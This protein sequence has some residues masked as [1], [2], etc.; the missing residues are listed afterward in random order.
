MTDNSYQKARESFQGLCHVCPT[1]GAMPCVGEAPG[2]GGLG[3]GRSFSANIQAL[4]ACRLNMRVLHGVTQPETRMNLLGMDLAFPVLIAPLGDVSSSMG[5]Q[6][7]EETFLKDML[8]GALNSGIAGCTADGGQE[9]ICEAGF[10]TLRKV[11]GRGIPFLKPWN[12]TELFR[13]IDRAEALGVAAVGLDVDAVGLVE[14]QQQGRSVAPASPAR[15]ARIIRHT[16]LRCVVKGIMTPDEAC[17]A[18]DAGADAIVVSNYGGRVLEHTPGVAEVLPW[19]AEAVKGQ[20]RILAAGGVRSG[21][22]ILKMLALGADA[23]MIGR[24]FA[25][26]ALGSGRKGVEEC[27]RQLKR[28]LE[29]VM[30]LTGTMRVD[31]VSRS[32]LYVR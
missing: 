14:L 21:A 11:G 31:A 22:D 4:D 20:V 18:V 13:K 26:A 23:V 16:P 19:I 28:E 9:F 12:E 6:I 32:V 30:V 5:A 8:D 29:Q 15:L 2:M 7:S 27:A 17:I 10:Q 1:C 3:T 24:P 25:I